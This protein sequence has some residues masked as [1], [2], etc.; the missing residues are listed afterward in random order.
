MFVDITVALAPVSYLNTISWKFILTL[1][2]HE[3]PFVPRIV[4]RKFTVILLGNCNKCVAAA[5]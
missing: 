2:V 4:S 3:V 5:Y 1:V